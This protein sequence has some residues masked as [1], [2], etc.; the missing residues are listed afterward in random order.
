M[1]K[2]GKFRLQLHHAILVL[3]YNNPQFISLYRQEVTIG[4]PLRFFHPLFFT[5]QY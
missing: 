1:V 3:I 5:A 2:E 4:F